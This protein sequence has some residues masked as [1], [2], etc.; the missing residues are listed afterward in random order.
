MSE[1]QA[2]LIQEPSPKG[3]RGGVFR[4][5]RRLWRKGKFDVL[6]DD[7]KPCLNSPPDSVNDSVRMKGTDKK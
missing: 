2:R 7:A 3:K 5:F 4:W 6:D 1:K